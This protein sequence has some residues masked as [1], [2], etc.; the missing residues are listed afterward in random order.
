MISLPGYKIRQKIYESGTSIVL[1]ARKENADTDVVIKI[2]KEEYPDP[3]RIMRFKKEYENL[4]E[5]N[6][7]GI[8]KVYSIE[9]FNNR[10]ALIT[11][12]FGAESL[13]IIMQLRELS[14]IDFLKLSVSVTETMCQFSKL[15]I[16]HNKI[17]PTNI[18]WNQE[19]GQVKLIDFGSSTI[20]RR[21]I[22]AIQNPEEVE[23]LLSYISPEQ[24]GR[25]NR[26]VDYRTDMYSLGVTFYELLA[27]QLPFPSSDA[28]EI[29]HCHLARNPVHPHLIRPIPPGEKADDLSILSRIITK[30]MAKTAE[31]RYLS[32]F[33]LRSDLKRCLEY[34]ENNNTLSGL[35][36]NPGENDFSD[37]FQIP[38]KLYGREVETRLILD[39]FN[40]VCD[41]SGIGQAGELII[42]SGYPGIGKSAL[43]NEIHIPVVENKGLF[44]SGK[45]DKFKHNIPYS[46]IVIAFQDLI[47]Q[48][49]MGSEVQINHWKS[50]I[51]DAVG[52]N[53]QVIIDVIPDVERIIGKQPSVPYLPPKETQN[54][55]YLYFQNFIETFAD[56][57]HPLALFLDDLQWADI[58][59]LKLLE[60]L[61][62]DLKARY[63]LIIGA[64]RDNEVDS[65]HPLMQTL[66]KLRRENTII[67][68][69]TLHNLDSRQIG[70]LISDSLRCNI[71]DI[72][73]IVKLC[74]EKTNGN[75]FF[76]IQFLGSLAEKN[77][78]RFNPENLRW[79]WD[80][81][82][83]KFT[84]ITSN[85]VDL[86][87]SKIRMMSE[88]TIRIL[89][90]ASCI[91][92]SFDLETLSI[93]N[94]RSFDETAGELNEALESG[95]IQPIGRSYRLAGYL[96]MLADQNY[97][98][99]Q[100]HKIPYK[101]LHDRVHQA[102]GSL[103]GDN[104]KEI[105]HKAG[106]LLL[107]NLPE[108]EREERIF[109][110]TN[111]L[112]TGVGLIPDEKEKT[113]LA[114]LNLQ[115]GRK[116]KAATAY[117]TAFQYFNTGLALI[118]SNAW[119]KDYDLT[120]DLNIEAA[121]AAHLTG[122]FDRTDEI[123]REILN[124]ATSLLDKIRINEIVIQ[125]FMSRDRL[126][127]S[128][129]IAIEILKQLGVHLNQKPGKLSVI[130]NIYHLRF[131]TGLKKDGGP[132]EFAGN[133]RSL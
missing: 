65:L 42:V 52:P 133:D 110:I 38:Q 120:L 125:S 3:E 30:L 2:L 86:M 64:Y 102:V 131:D 99:R 18:V 36:F 124:H 25:M 69:I 57:S 49:L 19:T 17:N 83:I 92:T 101:F 44:V 15:N 62:L 7:D 22:A 107:Q 93:I 116:A 76:L 85:V 118:G 54:R 16:I 109:D 89:K 20:L 10:W 129:A 112:N 31:D 8:I 33:G 126:N 26:M 130:L 40:R 51:L 128:I 127:E 84:D 98:E 37:K 29:I 48:I 43:V 21:E 72:E 91:G 103:M 58:P 90:L 77:L 82:A 80:E 88:K 71:E 13:K 96:G 105:H 108:A 14:I 4:K 70:H 100:K 28:M 9:K 74:L 113:N 59:S 79:E 106:M 6:L 78:I 55:F 11:E 67:N 32:F 95:L 94:E 97:F 56:P 68:Y 81:E 23:G 35:D 111:L 73:I 122:N 123:A 27:G 121:E 24:T 34:L 114:V 66:N 119:E 60:R 1:R 46:A 45:F 5:I 53:G 117:E 47:R 87:T 12:D 39:A 115:A 104:F 61:I 75:P 41:I 50:K 63:L 132:E